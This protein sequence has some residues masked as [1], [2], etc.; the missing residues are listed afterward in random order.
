MQ[1][2]G[3]VPPVFSILML[4]TGERR[5]C[6]Q[7]EQRDQDGILKRARTQSAHPQLCCLLYTLHRPWGVITPYYRQE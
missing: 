5:A 3:G 4:I 2:I 1:Q 7:V 6:I